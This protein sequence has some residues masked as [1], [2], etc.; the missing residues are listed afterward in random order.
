MPL[1][2]HT[3]N[4]Q[5]HTSSPSA[6]IQTTF[7]PPLQKTELSLPT[8]PRSLGIC[9]LL[10]VCRYLDVLH[11]GMAEAVQREAVPHARVKAVV[12]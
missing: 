9:Y 10:F 5:L 2:S 4:T 1:E 3:G 8:R 6:P 7:P 12:C 11:A